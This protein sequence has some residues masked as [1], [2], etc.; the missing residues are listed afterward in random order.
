MDRCLRWRQFCSRDSWDETLRARELLK[1]SS[2]TVRQFCNLPLGAKVITEIDGHQATLKQYAVLSGKL[3]ALKSYAES[4]QVVA[5]LKSSSSQVQ[6]L[7]RV[8]SELQSI[9]AMGGSGFKDAFPGEIQRIQKLIEDGINLFRSE[10]ANVVKNTLSELLK[11]VVDK[12][13]PIVVFATLV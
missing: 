4:S 3:D 11:K 7:L 5:M 8:Q 6:P 13:R 10:H 2:K 9:M 12:D 1:S